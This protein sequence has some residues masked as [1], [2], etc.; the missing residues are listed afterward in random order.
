MGEWK[1]FHRKRGKDK[2]TSRLVSYENGTETESRGRDHRQRVD[3]EKGE[4]REKREAKG[5][6]HT[7]NL[8][9]SKYFL[10]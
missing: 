1:N 9:T 7:N 10:K 5:T 2:L 3:R 4:G 8:H 6:R